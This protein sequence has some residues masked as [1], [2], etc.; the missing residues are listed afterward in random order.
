MTALPG[1][2]EAIEYGDEASVATFL[3]SS[4]ELV[5]ATDRHRKTPLHV[6]VEH[7]REAISRRLLEAGN[8]HRETVGFLLESGARTDLKDD[9]FHGTPAS[10]AVEFSHPA[11]A[12]LLRA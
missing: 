8:G 9:Q 11:I 3:A 10:W 4:P 7:D 1:F 6:A 5:R 12:A 2:F